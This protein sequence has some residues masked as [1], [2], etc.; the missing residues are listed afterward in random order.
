MSAL[1]L[2]ERRYGGWYSFK[3]HRHLFGIEVA[4]LEGLGSGYL[5]RSTSPQFHQDVHNELVLMAPFAFDE[6]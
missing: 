5:L 6:G 1:R 2:L 4:R 3:K